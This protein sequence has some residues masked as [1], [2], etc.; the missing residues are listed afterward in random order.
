MIPPA[1]GL[2]STESRAVF[3]SIPDKVAGSLRKSLTTD[4][5][6]GLLIVI[7]ACVLVRIGTMVMSIAFKVLS[8]W[9]R[10]GICGWLF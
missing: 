2:Q 9:H 7:V 10:R 3:S 1:V 6:C 4:L 5:S 8:C